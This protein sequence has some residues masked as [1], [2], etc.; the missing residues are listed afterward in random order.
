MGLTDDL[1]RLGEMRRDGVLTDEE[2]ARA[3]AAL[4]TAPVD[5]SGPPPFPGAASGPATRP[6]PPPLPRA[7]GDD[8]SDGDDDGGDDADEPPRRA[9][10]ASRRDPDEQARAERQWAMY[11]HF[12]V[13]AGVVVPLAGFVLPIVLWQSKR[14]EL[15]GVDAHGRAVTNWLISALIYGVGATILA[16][17]VV[18]I[19]LLIALAVLCLV[20]PIVGG[21]RAGEGTLWR[22]PLTIPFLG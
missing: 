22:Y 16:F 8:P 13:L 9:E 3:K 12:S 10:R 21:L 17:V 6:A 15:P 19:P 20:F 5:V 2:F 18:G 7:D 14:H 1:A 11:I 4:L